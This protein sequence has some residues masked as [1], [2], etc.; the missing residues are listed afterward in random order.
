[1]IKKSINEVPL[2]DVNVE[3][4]KD[5]KVQWIFSS[6]DNVPNFYFRIFHVKEGG[7]TPKHK[8]PWEHEVLILEGKGKV[9]FE[10]EY[11]DFKEGDAFFIPPNKEH[12]FLAETNGKF[13]CLIP[14]NGK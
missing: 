3:G 2:E 6:K 7:S 13:I 14:K 10:D 11:I 9:F 8:H 12:Q 1:M 5:V 4:A